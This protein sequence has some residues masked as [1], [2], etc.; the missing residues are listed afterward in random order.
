MKQIYFLVMIF[1]IFGF[2]QAQE[3]DY[4]AL[5]A[6][7]EQFEREGL[8]KSALQVVERIANKALKEVNDP[9]IIKTLL[10]KSKYA[11]VLEED[12]QLHI[13]ND[14]KVHI[15]KSNFPVKHIL[16]SILANLYWQYFQENRWKFYNRTK[17]AEPL[18]ESDFR[19]WDL[20][21]LFGAIHI[22]FQNAL[23][24]SLMLQLEPLSKY[25]ALLET[26]EDSKL[27]RPTL[28][29]FLAHMALDFYK[30]DETHIT[31]PA[32]AFEINGQNYLSNAETYSTLNISSKDSTSLQL[33]AVQ[34]YKALIRFHLNDS[35]PHALADVDIERL[36]FIY[37]H[38]T[39][40]AKDDA[41]LAALK[42]QSQDMQEHEASALY[43]FEIAS[44]YE[45][46]SLKYEPKTSTQYRWKAKQALD[47]CHKVITKFPKSRGAKNCEV[48]KAKIQQK[49]LRLTAESY[50]PINTHS[51]IL[52]SYKN[53]DSLNFSVY[54]VTEDEY[55]T[56]N[57]TYK[58]EAQWAFI[59]KLK[60]IHKWDS[61]LKNEND[62]QA[63]S[64]EVLVPKLE[65]GRFLIV[66]APEINNASHFAFAIVNSTDMALAESD[67]QNE[68]TFQLINRNNGNPIPNAKVEIAFYK[69]GSRTVQTD[70][71]VSNGFGEFK[72]K[73]T[74]NNWYNNVTV[75][76]QHK[77]ETAYFGAYS[78]GSQHSP[79]IEKT[80][81][82]AFLFTDRSIYRPGQTLYFKG[83]AMQNDNGK[84]KVLAKENLSVSLRN[85]NGE[86]LKTLHLTTNDF[87]SVAGTFILP[88]NG[89]NGAY[90]LALQAENTTLNT[91]Y[92]FAVEEYKRPKFKA[93]F[94]AITD[95]YRVNDSVDVLGS[96]V[97]FSGAKVSGAGVVYRVYRK[98][99]YPRWYSWYRP[100][101]QI[102]SQEIAYGE[103]QT[104]AEGNFTVPFKAIPD[105][106]VDQASLPVFKYN[107]TADI[108]DINGETRSTT[109]TVNVGY[110]AMLAYLDAPERLNKNNKNHLITIDTKN[111]NGVA[112]PAKGVIKLYKLQ[113]PKY[114]LRPRP[115]PAPE[116]QKFSKTE[117][118]ALF[119]YD[120]YNNEDNPLNWEKGSL[121]FE[122]VFNT[123]E[124][125]DISLGK[126]KKWPSGSYIITLESK[127]KYGQV[128]K[129]E[130]RTTIYGD[131]D[132][133]LA[134]N[135]LFEIYTNKSAYNI[136]DTAQIT[137]GTS[138]DHITV[139]VNIEK[140]KSTVKQEIITLNNSKRTI[141]IPVTKD[142]LGGFSVNYS[143]A[144][145]NSFKYGS[146]PI[147]VPYPPT[148]LN[149]ET[150]TFR[151]KLEP[152]TNETWQFKL[153]GPKGEKISA[154]LLASMYD[155]SLDEFKPHQ[156]YFNPIIHTSY[157]S[158]A[159]RSAF[160]NFGT[161]QFR[162][163]QENLRLNYV[164]QNYDRF[165]WFGFKFGNYYPTTVVER[166]SGRVAGV[167]M[168]ADE[169]EEEGSIM[170]IAKNASSL[171][172]SVVGYSA[173]NTNDAE[174]L[175]K[176]N[177]SKATPNFDTIAI[178]KNL[179]ETAFFFPQLHTDENGN[180]S[181]SF[182]TPE[183]LTQWKLQLLAHTTTLESCTKNFT[184]ITQ[185]ELMVIPNAPRFLRQG[186]TIS[187]STKISNLS[188]N[189]LYGQAKLIL[190]DAISG[191]DI[192][193]TLSLSNSTQA[194]TVAQKN[195]T[196]VSWNLNIPD[197]VQAVQY[198][199]LA[200][201]G[202]FSDGEQNVLPVLSN[203]I[204]VTETLPIWVK[205]NETRTFVLDKLKHSHSASLKHHKL[206]LEITSNPAW[207]AI[208]TLP[209][210]MEYPYD[211]NEQ[212]FARYYAN[213]LAG[214]IANSNPKIQEV[215][216]QWRNMDVLLSNLE[217]NDELKSILINETPWLRDAQSETEQK[218]RIALLFDLNKMQNELQSALTK[219]KTNQ[220]NSGAWPWFKGGYENRYIT[221]H[222][223]SG[224][225][226]LE[227]LG[228][229]S[230]SED[231]TNTEII[232]KAIQY[233]D[234]EFLKEYH[235][236]KKYNTKADLSQDH[237]SYM[238]LH[239]L[240]M[241]SF[242][243]NIKYSKEVK[244]VMAYYQLQIQNYWLKRSLYAK[245]MMALISYRNKDTGTATKILNSLKET[246]ITSSELGMYWKENTNS[247][248]WYQAP[249]ET[250]ALIIEAFADIENDTETIDNLKIWLL[251][252][253]QTNKWKTTKAT[254]EAIYALLLQGSDWLSVSNMVNVQLGNKPI[255]PSKLENVKI[256][257]GTGYYKT[258]WEPMEIQPKMAE[259]KITKTGKGIAWGGLYWQ[260]FED[261]NNITGAKT[262]LQLHKALFLKQN[263]DTGEQLFKISPT[264]KLGVGD[265]IRVRIELKSDRDMQFLHMK[266][267]RASGLE[268]LNVMSQYKWQ[269]GLGYYESTKDASTNF[270][271]DYMP[272]GLYVFEYDL[273]VNNPGHM[274]NGIT[275]IQSMYAPEFSSHSDG[276]RIHVE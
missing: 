34:L 248:H 170:A 13:V 78:V 38:A 3:S 8:P 205:G 143:F 19:T 105:T 186:D 82:R 93:A 164:T 176:E 25:S 80:A 133:T 71:F 70:Y 166:L 137:L 7:V 75:K 10:Y 100:L 150:L 167:Q 56:F 156:W 40:N 138:A 73:K 91:R 195:N 271:F 50:V 76:A 97:T 35:S 28:F 63:H 182:K 223:I 241:R 165:N 163:Y 114:V 136:G 207:Y 169:I 245:G 96:A 9:Q 217:K 72:I 95:T 57:K 111:L 269:D 24:N 238:Q 83:I 77:G 173:Q 179:E 175:D 43:N 267:M 201:S 86:N 243:Q 140:A 67:S 266:D 46:Q 240:Y 178:R 159:T 171:E 191:K 258:T 184:A 141:N 237:L 49:I 260:Y 177:L 48:L 213:A 36:K 157:F 193:S 239:Y 268:P 139:T 66:A 102:E 206:S 87:G 62:Y 189:I 160:N 20:E 229:I 272:K 127:D 200:T 231:K 225:G 116:Y 211:C 18:L 151:D 27:Y 251:K 196:Q 65:N 1:M 85:V 4:G 106:S 94:S 274:S 110:H 152:G 252:H 174:A 29:D 37:E 30:T 180:V 265:V 208:Q 17:T 44:F 58:K 21:T 148:D 162:A 88:N 236:I 101:P 220:M 146:I 203:R 228:V 262:P 190:T 259:V 125:K 128:V 255:S 253:K 192:T 55:K 224:F 124:S 257:A 81:Y 181:F 113:A 227:K 60:T 90:H 168:M 126:L 117:F 129:D 232:S 222:I 273:R 118:K 212:T 263:T 104:D 92:Y 119:P 15:K 161:T 142:A 120:A 68:K 172:K 242:F 256:E 11:L 84:S 249:I 115:W 31:K 123:A 218:K 246:S 276:L 187:L 145:F 108:T 23:E 5:W 158:T 42:Y 107:V 99:E 22:H 74:K 210:L 112:V 14:F 6:E 197:S 155:A 214:H 219:L 64:T 261:L 199:I 216:K 270:F 131:T 226:H 135:A 244:E 183:A 202:S 61:P 52:V 235:D 45:K 147:A 54:A 132:E 98:V 12:A 194:F 79:N 185:K 198:K 204:L 153:K 247:R 209:Y 109:T 215:F 221:Q 144:A 230:V 122:Q 250:Q 154:E 33:K 39:F 53:M 264:T 41:F 16:E 47:L 89:L 188:E 275:T 59:Q 51:R 149:I 233:L 103:T 2:C 69:R 134:D 26:T 32:F 234:A 121:V 254:T 130:L